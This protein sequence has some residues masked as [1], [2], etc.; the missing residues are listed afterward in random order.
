MNIMLKISN[1]QLLCMKL[2][3]FRHLY[4]KLVDSGTITKNL[5]TLQIA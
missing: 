2:I 5:T 3:L 4:N 1:I